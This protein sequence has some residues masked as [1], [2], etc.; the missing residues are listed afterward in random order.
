MK[1]WISE[2]VTGI[3]G[4]IEQRVL[5]Q[6]LMLQRAEL[7]KAEAPRVW[8]ALIAMIEEDV[9]AFNAHFP[10][11]A[12]RQIEVAKDPM[13]LRVVVRNQNFPQIQLTLALNLISQTIDIDTAKTL[14]IFVRAAQGEP[15]RIA[16]RV[17]P[18]NVLTPILNG[19]VG[20]SIERMAELILTP[21]FTEVV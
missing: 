17:E 4:R 1:K 2:A 11:E 9:A 6:R 18:D 15:S 10:G 12:Q 20:Y 14:D 21:V 8:R 3:S 13:S 5:E 7:V 19:M 16:F